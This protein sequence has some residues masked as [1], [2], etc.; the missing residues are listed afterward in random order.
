MVVVDQMSWQPPSAPPSG[1]YAPTPGGYVP[2]PGGYGSPPGGYYGP[3][4]S[5]YGPP[6]GYPQYPGGSG[7]TPWGPAPGLEYASFWRR[8]GGYI[9]DGIIIG[10]PTAI[11]YL[12]IFGSTISTYANQVTYAN[13]NGLPT[14]AYVLPSGGQ[15]T[16]SLIGCVL[17]VLYFGVLV[18]GW[19]ST[20]GQR[21]VGVRVVRV[22]DPASPLPL[23]RA[24][25]RAIV[26]WAPGLL[27]FVAGVSSIAGLVVFLCLLWVAW[28]PK[29]QGLH[30]KLGRALVVRPSLAV[31]AGAYG[32]AY[33]YPAP[34]YL[35]APPQYL[36]TPQQYP[37]TPSQYPAAPPEYPAA[38]PQYPAAPPQ[39]PGVPPQYPPTPSL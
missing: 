1:G 25:A 23:G 38:P 28:D 15:V 39:Y 4:P 13:Q 5:G 8:F 17:A 32:A 34:G 10:V 9:L 2:T 29:K 30:D 18:A 33:P 21:A 14:P 31:P 24:L 22:E 11:I 16:L 12:I 27:A 37:P 3:P 6:P 26:W 35:G 7:A 19:G 20:L 36:P